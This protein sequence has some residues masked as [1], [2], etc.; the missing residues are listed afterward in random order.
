MYGVLMIAP[1]VL[2]LSGVYGGLSYR[3]VALDYDI[4]PIRCTDLDCTD[5]SM[6]MKRMIRIVALLMAALM[7]VTSCQAPDSGSRLAGETVDVSFMGPSAR[8]ITTDDGLVQTIP[9]SDL[10]FQYKA[11]WNGSGDPPSTATSG[12]T[13]L[14][15]QGLSG[16]VKLH[17]GV[18]NL[19]LR[20]FVDEYDRE[21]RWNDDCYILIGNE[22][23]VEVGTKNG[24]VIVSQTVTINLGYVQQDDEGKLHVKANYPVVYKEELDESGNPVEAVRKVKVTATVGDTAYTGEITSFNAPDA[25]TDPNCGFADIWVPGGAA[26]VTVEY[27]MDDTNIFEGDSAAIDVLIMAY[28]TTNLEVTVDRDVTVMHLGSTQPVSPESQYPVLNFNSVLD[29]Y[30]DNLTDDT[31]V[32]I[33]YSSEETKTLSPTPIA[34]PYTI[35]SDATPDGNGRYNASALGLTPIVVTSWAELDESCATEAWYGKSVNYSE[36]SDNGLVHIKIMDGA[37]SIASSAFESCHKLESLLIPN[38]VESIGIWAFELCSSLES[39]EIP[40]SVTSLGANAFN[41]CDA[42]KTVKIGNGVTVIDERT[43]RECESLESVT[44]G[45][46]IEEIKYEA[47]DGCY[48]LKNINLPEGLTTIDENAFFDCGF[49]SITI[50][51]SVTRIEDSAFECCRNLLSIVIPDSVTYL[52]ERVFGSCEKLVSAAIGKG[53]SYIHDTIFRDSTALETITVS[54]DNTTYASIDGVLIDKVNSLLVKYPEGKK[55]ESY[56]I[57]DSVTTI[58][59]EAFRGSNYLKS[60]TIPNTVTDIEYAAFEY[61][62]ELRSAVLGNGL[63]YIGNHMFSNCEKLSSVSIPSSVTS[64]DY[65]AFVGCTG[66]ESITIPDSVTS[67]GNSAFWDCS[68]LTSLSI[69]ASVTSI[70]V[71]AFTMCTSLTSIDVSEGNSVFASMDGILMN[72]A[73]TQLISYPSGKPVCDYIV[74]DNITSIGESAFEQCNNITSIVI[75][76]SVTSIGKEAFY[77]SYDYESNFYGSNLKTVIIGNGLNSVGDYAFD[78][79]TSLTDIYIN[80]PESTLFN[81]ARV[82]DGCMIHWNSTGPESV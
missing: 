39:I 24:N 65:M 81:N 38:T 28:M 64:I 22:D 2:I 31:A 14:D 79:C 5:R 77:G 4:I 33:G 10:W 1:H 47:F 80:K 56:T 72:K 18:W 71:N 75:P 6:F 9:T 35:I 49:S 67:I 55:D 61:C 12:W 41:G 54:E 70:G 51:S 13:S 53:V 19:S 50:P 57:P 66:L 76:D 74:P 52:G 21:N 68:S 34:Y 59:G 46:N 37:T 48:N 7:V 42:L 44:L 78:Y 62:T 16:T 45:N 27:Y 32:V 3:H 30:P 11:V 15:G 29:I 23:N 73:K 36:F 69:P 20:A 17:R 40:D 25:E 43:F 8:T 26:H 63:T 60:V 58:G 82:P